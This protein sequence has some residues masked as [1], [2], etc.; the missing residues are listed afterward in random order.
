MWIHSL[1][2]LA[3][4]ILMLHLMIRL[5]ME[6]QKQ[7]IPFEGFTIAYRNERQISIKTKVIMLFSLLYD[8]ESWTSYKY[9]VNQLDT[10]HKHCLCSM[11]SVMIF[12]WHVILEGSWIFLDV[13]TAL[14]G[15][16]Y[17]ENERNKK[18]VGRLL[19]Y[20]KDKWKYNVEAV[21]IF[22]KSTEFAKWECKIVQRN[23]Y[24][25]LW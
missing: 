6:S 9:C 5:V 2:W 18:G 15:R 12:S 25:N 17:Q 22:L 14:V 21:G 8:S 23:V 19:L 20:Y 7:L 4:L 11:C 10:F 1:I 16:S 24:S 3:K 13:V